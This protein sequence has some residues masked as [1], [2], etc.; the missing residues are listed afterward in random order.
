M[1]QKLI[2]KFVANW[3]EP[4]QSSIEHLY[5]ETIHWLLEQDPTFP[6]VRYFALKDLMGLNEKDSEL[7]KA[8]SDV[9]KSGPVLSIL[10]AQK[11]EGYWEKP[12]PGYSPKYTGTVWQLIFL[13]QFGADGAD[14][15]VRA[16]CEYVFSHNL[17]TNGIFSMTG[18]PSGFLHC[19]SG[20]LISA[21]IDFG[22]I[23]DDRLLKAV[24]F[25]ALYT[26]GA[27]VAKSS[28]TKAKIRYYRSGTSGPR[29]ACANNSHLPCSWGAIKTLLAFGKIPADL[30]N[31]T[32]K[33]AIEQSVSFLLEHDPAIADYP[34]ERGA[35]PS[36]SWFKFGYPLGYNA[37]V[38]QNLEAL[39]LVGYIQDPHLDSALKLVYS[40]QNKQERWNQECS[41]KGKMWAEIEK[42]GFPSK[43]VT[44]R[45]MRI[46]KAAK[47]I[48][49]F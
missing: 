40:K 30:R 46:F 48:D 10:A 4:M 20:N 7:Q 43:W 16:A 41:Y 2:T 26:I 44:L 8:K 37:D 32:V 17:A 22:H 35:K 33:K 9:M 34:T 5:Q 36:S 38:L 15:R 21:L 18:A 11:P 1:L 23:E 42:P 13:S 29:F 45:V 39:A 3:T 27:D 47:I 31:K 49:Y 25:H 28:S 19:L 12:G 6:G 14:K 24:E